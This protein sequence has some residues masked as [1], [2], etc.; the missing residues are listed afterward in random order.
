MVVLRHRQAAHV[1]AVVGMQMAQADRIDLGELTVELQRAEGPAAKIKD[2]AEV[3]SVNQVTGRRAGRAGKTARPADDRYLHDRSRCSLA[4]MMTTTVQDSL[5][6]TTAG[7]PKRVD[8]NGVP[9]SS[10]KR[11]DPEL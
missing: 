7:R 11:H 6:G 5:A 8:S 10:P 4:W 9:L 3:A 1:Q 2:E